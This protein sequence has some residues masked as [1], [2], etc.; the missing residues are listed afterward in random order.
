M[1][2]NCTNPGCTHNPTTVRALAPWVLIGLRTRP[3]AVHRIETSRLGVAFTTHAAKRHIVRERI[4]SSRRTSGNRNHALPKREPQEVRYDIIE[5][6]EP[7]PVSRL[8]I[9]L[10]CENGPFKFSNLQPA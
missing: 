7:P 8:G 3:I 10:K 6:Q 5:Q 1:Q 4:L 2:T 9:L